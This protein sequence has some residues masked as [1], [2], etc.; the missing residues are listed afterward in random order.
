MLL[1]PSAVAWQALGSSGEV[2]D[3]ASWT[4][5]GR[6]V[7]WVPLASGV[8]MRQIVRNAW[9]VGRDIAHQRPTLLRLR[10]AYE[11]SLVAAGLLAKRGDPGVLPV[12]SRDGQAADVPAAGLAAPGCRPPVQLRRPVS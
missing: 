10:P 6:P 9:T 8:L 2:P 12:G 1:S 5:D 4:V 11:N 7:P 3:T